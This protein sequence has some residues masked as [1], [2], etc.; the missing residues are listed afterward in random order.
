MRTLL[1]L[2]MTM[3][4]LALSAQTEKGRF[5][6]SGQTSMDFFYG[7]DNTINFRPEGGTNSKTTYNVNIAPA[8]GYFV[9]DNLSINLQGS[10]SLQDGDYIEKMS[11]L[12][13]MP[14]ASYYFPI[15][16]KFRPFVSAGVGYATIAQFVPI[17]G[18]GVSRHSFNGLTW[19]V[20]AGVAFF[21]NKYLSLD[22]SLEYSDVNTSYSGDS[23]V[24]MKISGVGGV[25]GFSLYI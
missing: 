20:G 13:L 7:T 2:C 4:T 22:L 21:I 19:G 17:E 5:I 18:S 16:S 11:Q 9:V 12:T 25:I 3:C 8:V 10:Y 6:I 14:S 23:S 15:E 1:I 24:K